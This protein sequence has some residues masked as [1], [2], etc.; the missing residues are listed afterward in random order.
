[1]DYFPET[2]VKNAR[3]I[4]STLNRLLDSHELQLKVIAQSRDL[5]VSLLAR[6]KVIE[7]AWSELLF[8]KGSDLLAREDLNLASLQPEPPELSELLTLFRNDLHARAYRF[9]EGIYSRIKS[10]FT[11]P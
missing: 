8:L 2:T 7:N 4:P 1:M 5:V 10:V 9:F 6:N 3:S 11:R